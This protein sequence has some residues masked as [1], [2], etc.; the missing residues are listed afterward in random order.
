MV[1]YLVASVV[2]YYYSRHA[3]GS[4]NLGLRKPWFKLNIIQAF[5]GNLLNLHNSFL[6]NLNQIFLKP[7][8]IVE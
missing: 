5:D 2:E 8:S 4:Q 7:I 3:V 1:D 6:L